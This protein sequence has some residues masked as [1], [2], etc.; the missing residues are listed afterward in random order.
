MK[1]EQ[2]HGASWALGMTR[3]SP[4]S[5]AM[6]G[7]RGEPGVLVTPPRRSVLL[8]ASPSSYHRGKWPQDPTI[9]RSEVRLFSTGTHQQVAH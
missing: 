2:N 1:S 5:D 4:E 7:V 8:A 6:A 3:P 9:P